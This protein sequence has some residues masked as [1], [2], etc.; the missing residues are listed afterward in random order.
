EV[1]AD[2]L[3]PAD[4]FL[5]DAGHVRDHPATFPDDAREIGVRGLEAH[6]LEL[7]VG[8]IARR[9]VAAAERVHFGAPAGCGDARAGGYE[10]ARR[11]RSGSDEL[12]D[13]AGLHHV[14]TEELA[15]VLPP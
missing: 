9:R 6:D 12:A 3:Q 5:R 14:V 10:R 1:A 4:P 8:R 2:L 15:G 7:E 11:V 13:G